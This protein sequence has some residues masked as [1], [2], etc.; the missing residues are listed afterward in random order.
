MKCGGFSVTDAF[1]LQNAVISEA[2][3][4]AR[5]GMQHNPSYWPR[6]RSD[7]VDCVLLSFRHCEIGKYNEGCISVTVGGVH[8]SLCISSPGSRRRSN[9]KA[10]PHISRSCAHPRSARGLSPKSS[11][12]TDTAA[13]PT[14]SATVSG[15]N[16]WASRPNS[17]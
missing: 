6:E 7:P 10:C 15:A 8:I 12:A 11:R 5:G 16:Y 2:V 9:E 4:A 3:V 17:R 14:H 1:D 13:G